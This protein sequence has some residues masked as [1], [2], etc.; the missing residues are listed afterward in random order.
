MERPEQHEIDTTA[1]RIFAYRLPKNWQ[2]HKSPAPEYGIDYEIEVFEEQRTTG[3]FFKVQLK[4]TKSADFIE[5]GAFLSFQLPVKI[6][7]YFCNELRIPLIFIL[8]ETTT[9][10]LWWTAPQM[11]PDFRARLEAANGKDQESLVLHIP[12]KNEF[13]KTIGELVRDIATSELVNTARNLRNSP[14][15]SFSKAVEALGDR[16][17]IVRALQEKIDVVRINQVEELVAGKNYKE[18]T[19]LSVKIFENPESTIEARCSA[20]FFLEKVGAISLRDQGATTSVLHEHFYKCSE[21]KKD[22]TRRGPRSLKRMAMIE[23]I[24]AKLS[25]YTE[26]EFGQF[27]N[28]K[29]NQGKGDPFWLGTLIA[30]R[31][32]L[33]R[34]LLK[35]YER[36]LSLLA[37]M[38]KDG[39]L[40]LVP[41]CVL[42]L[43]NAMQT[44]VLRLWSENLREAAMAYQKSNSQLRCRRKWST[45]MK[46]LFW[47]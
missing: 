5:D 15:A 31:Q 45:G 37:G 44:F 42:V 20:L 21:I 33:C 32:K 46:S 18:S 2:D 36:G 24:A 11:D 12:S 7:N 23:N 4:G 40:N 6:A 17:G 9:E 13:P 29:V 8:C 47:W 43:C 41:H 35:A 39:D 27:M 28:W 19:K 22:L 14:A 25:I 26:S 1:G 3:L 30:A 10:R 38:I 16:D 34:K